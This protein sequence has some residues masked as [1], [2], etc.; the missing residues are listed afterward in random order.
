MYSE[1]PN[2]H[3]SSILKYLFIYT[4]CVHVMTMKKIHQSKSLSLGS[5]NVSGFY[6]LLWTFVY[7]P[8]CYFYTQKKKAHN[9]KMHTPKYCVLIQ[10]YENVRKNS[11][12]GITTESH[13]WL[14]TGW[15][16]LV[17]GFFPHFYWEIIDIHHYISWRCVV[18]WFDLHVLWSRLS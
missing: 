16:D 5:R 1:K 14:L 6:F 11:L 8:N 18:W 12:M 9:L 10:L 7:F 15:W 13:Q 3:E 2:Q 4:V 17:V